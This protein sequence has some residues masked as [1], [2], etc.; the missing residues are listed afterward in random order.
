MLVDDAARDVHALMRRLRPDAVVLELCAERAPAAMAAALAGVSGDPGSS[1]AVIPRVVRIEGLPSR[2]IP[3]ASEPELLSLLRTRANAVVTPRDLVRDR[4]TLLEL[5]YFR[6][7]VAEARDA[8]PRGAAALYA[9]RR[10]HSDFDQNDQ[11]DQNDQNDRNDQN[12]QRDRVSVLEVLDVLGIVLTVA[13]DRNARVTAD[14]RFSWGRRARRAFGDRAAVERKI[15]ARALGI[16][17]GDQDPS[18][19]E[20]ERRG[21]EEDVSSSSSRDDEDEDEDEDEDD[22]EDDDEDEDEDSWEGVALRAA[23]LV[24]A[25][26]E[27]PGARLA[28]VSVPGTHADDVD[29]GGV[30]WL[31]IAVDAERT[32]PPVAAGEVGEDRG[33]GEADRGGGGAEEV[34][35]G[36]NGGAASLATRVARAASAAVAA[37]NASLTARAYLAA[38]ELAQELVA[39]RLDQKMPAGA[40]TVAAL[41][42]AMASGTDAVVLGDALASETLAGVVSATGPG[43]GAAVALGSLL[44]ATRRVVFCDEETL[45]KDVSAALRTLAAAE[46]RT[47]SDPNDQKTENALNDALVTR[48]DDRLFH[49]AWRA[50]GGDAAEIGGGEE[51]PAYVRVPRETVP[52]GGPVSEKENDASPYA[53]YAYEKKWNPAVSGPERRGA[54]V[55]AVVGAA[56]V[57]GITS[58]WREKVKTIKAEA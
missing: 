36:G 9:A 42:A 30:V 55:V 33:E 53:L 50:A 49:A 3:G 12:D 6:E 37:P 19:E 14:V 29:E 15:V 25:G 58:R 52:T 4:E 54:V 17:L 5:G 48:R 56:H 11:R 7:V 27:C 46:A 39:A 40:E 28:A 43:G 22:D 57:E 44:D 41:A 23:L 13:P 21:I 34:G 8:Q 35:N 10:E 47:I 20:R 51:V 18:R 26:V 31:S 38:S 16:L 45:R 32:L 24:S 2:P 1:P